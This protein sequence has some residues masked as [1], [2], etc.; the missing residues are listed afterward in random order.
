MAPH[1]GSESNGILDQQSMDSI[2]VIV[3]LWTIRAYFCLVMLNWARSVV[4]FP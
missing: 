1:V 4:R 2:G 3:V